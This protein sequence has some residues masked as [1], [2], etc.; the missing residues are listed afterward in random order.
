MASSRCPCRFG[1]VPA[2]P[3][4]FEQVRELL[5]PFAAD[6][7]HGGVQACLHVARRLLHGGEAAL[8]DA[9]DDDPAI[10]LAP[11]LLDHT[12]VLETIEEARQVGIVIHHPLRDLSARQ[13][14]G[15]RAPEDPQDV[16]LGRGQLRGAESLG[17]PA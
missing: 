4:A 1:F 7:I 3:H 12:A 2:G 15:P 17:D 14:V 5:E 8:R 10:L 9:R 6:R 13:P 16:E 11:R